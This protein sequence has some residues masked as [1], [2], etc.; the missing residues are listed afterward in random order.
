MATAGRDRGDGDAGHARHEH[1]QSRCRV[2]PI[3]ARLEG[4]VRSRWR[5]GL[6]YACY[7][8]GAGRGIMG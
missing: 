3:E 2:W 1:V 6:R 7:L 4:D 5:I 8:P